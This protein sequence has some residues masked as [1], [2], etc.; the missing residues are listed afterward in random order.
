MKNKIYQILLAGASIVITSVPVQAARSIGDLGISTDVQAL[1]VIEDKTPEIPNGSGY[2]VTELNIRS[3]PSSDSPVVGKYNKG[4][5]VAVQETEGEWA[6]TD[7][8]YVWGGYLS[9]E[10]P[11]GLNI[12][13]DSENASKYIGRAYDII[14]KL[15]EKYINILS[16]YSICVSDNPDIS[17]SN[18]VPDHVQSPGEIIDG[19]TYLSNAAAGDKYSPLPRMHSPAGTDFVEKEL[20]SSSSRLLQ[21]LNISQKPITLSV[22]KCETSSCFNEVHISN[23]WHI[24]IADDVS[25]FETSIYVNE[26]HEWN[27]ALKSSTFDTSHFETSRF[28]N[29]THWQ[30]IWSVLFRLFV[31]HPETLRY[32]R[33]PHP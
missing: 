28:F 9:N 1:A 31:F 21:S 5:S 32:S 10:P 29:D 20:R 8:G 30:N 6:K 19:Y 33:L 24:Y 14:S 22:L 3:G 16:E 15:D 26:L 12:K 27:I 17:I 18:D 23:I 11:V 13:S 4:D 7:K 2:S 25:H